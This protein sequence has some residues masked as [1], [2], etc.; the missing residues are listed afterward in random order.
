MKIRQ[1]LIWGAKELKNLK[2]S[3][4]DAEVLLSYVLKKDKSWLLANLDKDLSEKQ[5]TK[6]KKTIFQRKKGVPVAY[7]TGHKEFY[8]LDYYVDKNVLIPRPETELLVE[9]ALKLKNEP[10]ILE[11]GTGSGCV[12]ISMIVSSKPKHQNLW[13]QGK[14]LTDNKYYA[15]DISIGAL[16]I[17]RKN[18]RKHKVR[19]HFIKSNLFQ[20]IPKDTKFDI[21]IANLPY[22]DP[23]WIKGELKYEPKMALDGGLK[24][25]KIIDKF[26]KKATSYLSKNGII[27]MEIDPRQTKFIK[28]KAKKYLPN[29]KIFFKKDLSKN[30]RVVIFS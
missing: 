16:K 20:K 27:L 5:L 13:C 25:V 23:K 26:L 9:E 17:A 24:G 7:I 29:K 8:G 12:I 21:I 15:S 3:A 14:Q 30:N 28:N 1:A 10:K 2:S 19:I 18:A 11:M 4:L 22:L 6:F